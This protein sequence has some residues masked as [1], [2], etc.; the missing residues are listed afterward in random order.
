[1]T[2]DSKDTAI[3]VAYDDQEPYDASR[4]EKE[5]LRA[6]LMNAMSDLKRSGEV[7]RQAK[8]YFLS[9]DDRYLF[10]FQSVCRFLDVDPNT[11]LVVTGLKEPGTWT[12]ASSSTE[13]ETPESSDSNI[14]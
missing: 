5:L 11:I 13:Q 7:G 9:P 3:Y 1:M 10:A 2:K 14:E 4:P 6:I 8:A 12:R